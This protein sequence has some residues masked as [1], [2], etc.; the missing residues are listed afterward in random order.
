MWTVIR[1]TAG[2]K[3]V[4]II[5]HDNQNGSYTDP[6]ISTQIFANQLRVMMTTFL[7]ESI[8]RVVFTQISKRN[9]NVY[10]QHD[11]RIL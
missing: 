2:R 7:R 8:N 9:P 4:T 6:H 3:N 10:I 11:F 1:I 5:L